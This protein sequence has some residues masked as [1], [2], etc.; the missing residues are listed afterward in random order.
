MKTSNVIFLITLF[1]IF[2]AVHLCASGCHL[3]TKGDWTKIRTR[4]AIPSR[5]IVYVNDDVL[6]IYL[7]DA[8]TAL[9][10]VITDNNGRIVYQDCISSYQPGYTHIIVL[11]DRPEGEWTITLS[12]RYGELTGEF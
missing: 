11:A 6:S 9:T 3:P 12:H 7:E 5:P 1:I 8:L 10:V 2:P 4:S